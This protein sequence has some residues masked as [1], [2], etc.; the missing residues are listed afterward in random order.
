MIMGHVD[1]CGNGQYLRRDV[2]GTGGGGGGGGGGCWFESGI[3]AFM[4]LD[5]GVVV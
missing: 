5:E 3:G 2:S 1:P 4:D